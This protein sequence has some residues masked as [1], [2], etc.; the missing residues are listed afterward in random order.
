MS[1]RRWLW[2]A[3]L[4]VSAAACRP[5]AAPD[6]AV[7]A[8]DTSL[9]SQSIAFF[10][11]RLAA[12]PNNYPVA[13][14]LAG[15]YMLRFGL[16]ADNGDVERAEALARRLTT[17]APDRAA[18][19]SRLA[20]VLLARHKFAESLA[21]ARAAVA[22]DPGDED[23]RGALFDATLASGSLREAEEALGA[24]RPGALATLVRRSQWLAATGQAVGARETMERV[25]RA[26]ERSASRPPTV[27]WC[28]TEL[29]DLLHQER[30]PDA[31]QAV[32]R[33]AL[34]AQPGY[35][36]AVE[37]LAGLAA[38]AGEWQAADRGYRQIAADAHP[39]LYLRL[40]EVARRL[41]RESDR[42]RWEQRFLDVA[43]PAEN[44]ALYGPE[45]ALYLAERNAPGDGAAALA[46][47]RREMARRPTAES[48]DLLAW[49]HYRREEPEAALAA[50]D[51]AISVGGP[52]AAMTYH[53][54][55]ILEALGR[56]AE[57]D[58]LIRSAA[59]QA[60]L[61]PPHAR[62]DLERRSGATIAGAAGWTRHRDSP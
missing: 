43:A 1:G 60:S 57:A 61:L 16:A 14:R 45:L 10:E 48:L 46:I 21:A 24:M 4:V 55:R 35:R 11:A 25:C 58:S 19:L 41:G 5:G 13:E 31:A 20:G 38:A 44:E 8:A 42:V 51:R 18:A 52:S 47:A 54:G 39:D 29:A 37:Q 2:T 32:L 17:L 33:R 59:D 26:L 50:S 15:R 12:D 7:S 3:A 40:A 34:E 49:I 9:V 53:R 28:L 22:A 27:A 30:G 56:R 36:G 23:A 62:L 6:G